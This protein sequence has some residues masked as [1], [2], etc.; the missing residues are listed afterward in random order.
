[1]QT[2]AMPT[3][4]LFEG[5]VH[6]LGVRIYY[7]DTDFSGVVYHANYL[8]YC[9]RARSD[10]FRLAGIHHAELAA[11]PD[12]LAFA[13]SE[14]RVRFLRPARIDDALSIRTTFEDLRGARMTARQTVLRGDQTLAELEITVALIGADGRPRRP[15]AD[16]VA[17]L[18][19]YL[20]PEPTA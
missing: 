2:E 10:F 3:A 12:A 17:R 1:M 16:L 8:R 15:P 20:A 19:P 13:A 4:G 6:W 7:E 18:R 11:R 14:L 5:R 9:E